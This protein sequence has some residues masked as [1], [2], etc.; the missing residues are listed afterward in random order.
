MPRRLLI[1]SIALALLF[2]C[3][4]GNGAGG[5]GGCPTCGPYGDVLDALC[6]VIDRCPSATY[7]IAYRS[8]SE[9][10]GFLA[11]G[12]T[13]RL[14]ESG[15]DRN[16]DFSVVQ[17][18]P[19]IDRT[20]ADSCI[21]YL[22]AVTCDEVQ[23]EGLLGKKGTPCEN[24]TST[25]G[26][27][28]TS[29]QT[30]PGEGEP[31]PN[32]SCASGLY[33]TTAT[34]LPDMHA[35]TCAV[36]KKLPAMGED[37]K[38]SSSRCAS[39]LYCKYAPTDMSQTC[40]PL[41]DTGAA[42]TSPDQCV[43]NFCNPGSM[44]CDAHGN[45]GD[46]CM[47]MNDCRNELFCNAQ[48]SCEKKHPN[49]GACA[50]NDACANNGC[51]MAT[52]IC[53]MPD[54][55]ACSPN[56]G[57]SICASNYCDSMMMKC[58]PPKANGQP[59]MYASECSSNWCGSSSHTCEAHCDSSTPC[60]AGQFCPHG[61]SDAVCQPLGT[62]GA[63]CEN[64]TDCMSGYCNP[65]HGTCSNK[66]QIGDACSL[67]AECYPLSYCEM[68][69]CA[70]RHAPGDACDAIDGC[71]DPFLCMNGTCQP[72]FEECRGAPAGSF[73]TYLRVCDD[74]SYCEIPSFICKPRT[75]RGQ[76]CSTAPCAAD[77]FCDST[78][79]CVARVSAGSTCQSNDQCTSG[80]YC[81]PGTNGQICS[82]GPDGRPCSFE[83]PCPTGLFCGELDDVCHSPGSN[84]ARCQ[85]D[86]QCIAS[87]YCVLGGISNTGCQPRPGL[88]GACWTNVPCADG[89][90]C[91]E[92]SRT[93][94]ANQPQGQ[95]C[96]TDP[97]FGINCADGLYCNYDPMMR[98]SICIPR[99]DTGMTCTS[100]DMC[101]S[102]ACQY[103]N[104]MESCLATA[105]CVMQ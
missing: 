98:M 32:Q 75:P 60:P 20:A 49:G 104:G 81:V 45:E 50:A 54:G 83:M 47:T 103:E 56:G 23:S 13:C 95:M 29:S 91:D 53:G 37:C 35:L 90:Y 52:G 22:K 61:S 7:P 94:K 70:R 86:Q 69:K 14:T 105:Q 51:D 38:I 101:L 16:L 10:V 77:A 96:N 30:G 62:N 43:S 85:N 46:P 65:L 40:T 19:M 17:K 58:A 11:F 26:N 93:C 99:L 5:G 97:P 21:A 41:G 33:C 2:G 48:A 25:S 44:T 28:S 76:K 100:N 31:C 39:G 57:A 18:I 63:A 102:G 64:P 79:T 36:C 68:G 89:F 24:I 6:S 92:N 15:S 42:C 34:Y 4:K 82:A 72:M 84:G 71:Q 67:G 8:R 88:G 12:T 87:N 27:G 73:C 66:P 80:L 74:N 1:G 59:C 78:M 9:C 3:H 55:T